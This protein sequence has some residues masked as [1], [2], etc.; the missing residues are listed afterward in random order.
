MLQISVTDPGGSVFKLGTA[1]IRIRIRYTDPDPATQIYI[2]YENSFFVQIF[3]DFHLF[4][5]NYGII[6]KILFNI[7]YLPTYLPTYLFCKENNFP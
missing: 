4:K 3:H 6:W 7:K 1:W 2:S 5:L